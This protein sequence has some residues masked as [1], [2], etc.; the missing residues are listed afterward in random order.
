[1][2][3][4]DQARPPEGFITEEKVLA[5]GHISRIIFNG[6]LGEVPYRILCIFHRGAN[7]PILELHMYRAGS[8]GHRQP[9]MFYRIGYDRRLSGGHLN[10]E[11]K[12]GAHMNGDLAG[13]A[14]LTAWKDEDKIPLFETQKRAQALVWLENLAG[15][16]SGMAALKVVDHG[17]PSQAP[18]DREE[19]SQE[20]I[21]V[22]ENEHAFPFLISAFRATGVENYSWAE[23][24]EKRGREA[25]LL[26]HGLV[27]L[28]QLVEETL[29]ATPATLRADLNR[30]VPIGRALH[31]RELDNS[32]TLFWSAEH[33]RPRLDL[34]R[35]RTLWKLLLRTEKK[36]HES[37]ISKALSCL[38]EEFEQDIGRI[39]DAAGW[40]RQKP[41]GAN[42]A[43]MRDRLVRDFL[44]KKETDSMTTLMEVEDKLRAEAYRA[45]GRDRTGYKDLAASLLRESMNR[46]PELNGDG[47]WMELAGDLALAVYGGKE[48]KTLEFRRHIRGKS[49][50]L[51]LFS[52]AFQYFTTY[53]QS[54]L[55]IVPSKNPSGSAAPAAKSGSKLTLVTMLSAAVGGALFGWF[56]WQALTDVLT[57]L[58]AA[59]I[60]PLFTLF[61]RLFQRMHRTWTPWMTT[62]LVVIYAGM[63]GILSHDLLNWHM[64]TIWSVVK[65]LYWVNLAIHAVFNLVSLIFAKEMLVADNP[66]AS[67][68]IGKPFTS[69]PS[70][71]PN[72]AQKAQLRR[73]YL[74][75][76]A[77]VLFIVGTLFGVSWWTAGGLSGWS[78]L[79]KYVAGALVGI[80]GGWI[81][82]VL[83]PREWN[84]TFSALIKR[85]SPEQIPEFNPTAQI[86]WASWLQDRI[87]KD[88]DDAEHGE[89]HYHRAIWLSDIHL[90]AVALN[91]K[92]LL[93]FL[94]HNKA[95]ILYINGDLIGGIELRREW[96]WDD[97]YNEFFKKLLREMSKGTH[98]V[99]LPGNHDPFINSFAGKDLQ[100]ATI[101]SEAVHVTAMGRRLRVVHGHEF[102]TMVLNSPWLE[103]LGAWSMKMAHLLNEP[104]N[105][106]RRWLRLPPRSFSAFLEENVTDTPEYLASH[107]YAMV[108][109]RPAGLDGAIGGHTHKPEA[110]II[111]GLFYGNSGDAVKNVTALVEHPD[112]SF[113]VVPLDPKKP[114]KDIN[115]YGP[116]V[117]PGPTMED[118]GLPPDVWGG[119]DVRAVVFD[120]DNTILWERENL[121]QE[122]LDLMEEFHLL[123]RKAALGVFTGDDK[124][125]TDR[126]LWDRFSESVRKQFVRFTDGGGMGYSPQDEVVFEH[127]MPDDIKRK[128]LTKVTETLRETLQGPLGHEIGI[129]VMILGVDDKLAGFS[130]TPREKSV[131]DEIRDH[132][133]QAW[134]TLTERVQR[135]I[136]RDT[137]LSGTGYR[138]VNSATAIDLLRVDKGD[139][140]RRFAELSAHDTGLAVKDILRYT[141]ALGDS[142]N[143]VPLLNFVVEASG[144]AFWVGK[145]VPEELDSRVHVL[146]TQGPVA[147]RQVLA[148]LNHYLRLLPSHDHQRDERLPEAA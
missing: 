142:A 110:K 1:M 83:T 104:L 7:A 127:R 10:V 84:S 9:F 35:F 48:R 27:R 59:G 49:R 132:H 37:A 114:T 26:G 19:I 47:E 50:G 130:L 44:L 133:P 146:K 78:D 18:A 97:E 100:G 86:S 144:W 117:S 139:A 64:V 41:R 138:A 53:R 66:T 25:R 120:K 69:K 45:F 80:L 135:E 85:V 129:T 137:E 143:D 121:Q 14:P 122:I 94:R 67:S 17:E 20:A 73:I 96:H 99:I 16:A 79:R 40:I 147:F 56:P 107:E 13:H 55:C 4:L 57:G 23:L 68:P 116:A 81:W 124:N 65:H 58:L 11:A 125:T 51:R 21:L 141:V 28:G 89:I 70:A 22:S 103:H 24:L 95:P 140:L 111:D 128:L 88:V 115:S 52:E 46:L 102:D 62:G 30:S 6:K 82:R 92:K 34:D 91:P 29:E 108:K 38:R 126:Q 109:S 12:V 105:A 60:E 77:G 106:L 43:R 90:G 74:V 39:A 134:A 131:M 98:I 119:L 3:G 72:G 123:A 5:K 145:I 93:R 112:G 101:V 2:R 63:L 148:S 113:E 118:P 75:V 15:K 8:H 32:R 136:A 42:L 71:S 36:T 61:P 54:L 33:R 31:R 87:P 76:G